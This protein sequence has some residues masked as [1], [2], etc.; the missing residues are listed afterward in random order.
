M[1]SCRIHEKSPA[2]I[3]VKNSEGTPRKTTDGKT[4]EGMTE[5]KI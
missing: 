4:T 1:N 2:G 5:K 3:P